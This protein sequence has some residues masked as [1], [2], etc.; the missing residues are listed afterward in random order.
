MVLYFRLIIQLSAM[1]PAGAHDGRADG[2]FHVMNHGVGE[3]F[4]QP[5]YFPFC[6]DDFYLV[7]STFQYFPGVPVFHSKDL[8]HWEQIGACLTRPSQVN[9]ENMDGNNGI[10]APTI[11]YH[12]GVFYMVTTIFPSRK[13]FYVYTDNPAGEWSDPIM[14]DFVTGSCD[15]TLFVDEGKCYFLWKDGTIK[16]CEID[17]NTGKQLS[18]IKRLWSG[19]GGRYPEGPHLYKKDGYYY[20]LLAE[21]GTEHGHH[22][23]LAR[24]RY[25]E[26]P[27][28]PCPSNPI[29]S[30]FNNEMQNSPIQGLGHADFVQAPDGSWWVIFLGYRTHGYLQH[31]M[32]RETFLAPVQ[33][34]K[35]SWPV[36]NKNGTVQ[37]NM[38]CKTLPQVKLPKDPETD[39]FS[40]TKL[41][42]CWSYL[43]N[44]VFENYSLT[45]R[46]GYL[47]MKASEKTIDQVGTLTF[48]GRRQTEPRFQ[49]TTAI[50]VSSLKEGEEAGI[51]AYAAHTNHYDVVV[52]CRGG[53]KYVKAYI[54]IGQVRHVEKKIS[55]NTDLI[56]LRIEGDY[57]YYHLS[58]SEDNHRFLPL[59][60]MEY[61]YL[62]TETIGGFTGVHLGLFAQQAKG[63]PGGSVDVDWFRY[64]VAK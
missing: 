43:C 27:Y 57:N 63:K 34:E 8:I 11:R 21:G 17:V 64:S 49:A 40:Q 7:N 44:P 15:P 38:D 58:Y 36:V 56:Y 22:V 10:Y 23:T 52:E 48:I 6:D 28:T 46:K 59:G 33:W 13:H 39:D 61:R 31:V 4:F 1:Q 41:A 9:L 26:G 54:R 3:I 14:I 29:L 47:R 2:R 42:W 20:L 50:D 53:K 16:I 35:G 37:I 45:E 5:G 55:L 25:L 30:H 19:M 18:E 24:S 60:K 51:T 12:D 62:S 32:G